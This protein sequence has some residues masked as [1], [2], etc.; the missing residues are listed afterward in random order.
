MKSYINYLLIKL[1]GGYN[2]ISRRQKRQ[3]LVALDAF[4]FCLAIYLAFWLRFDET[5]PLSGIV[6][7][8]W[9]IILLIVVKLIGFQVCGIYRPILRYT[10]LEFITTALQAV[11]YSSGVLVILA[12]L[13]GSWPLPRSVLII[14]AFLTLFLLIG[15]RLLIRSSTHNLAYYAHSNLPPERLV[16]YGAGAA[17]SQLAA[18]L[19]NQRTY[20]LIAF[21]DDNSDLQHRVVIQGLKVYSP[22]KLRLLWQ[23]KAFDTVILAMPSVTKETKRCI[24]EGL[25]SLSIP[26]KTVPS[27]NEILSGGVSIEKLRKIDIADLLGREEAAPDIELLEMQVTGKVVLV[28]GAGGSIGS[29]LCR[30]IAKQQPQ[31]LVLYELSEFALYNIDLELAETYPQLQ[32]FAYLGNVTDKDHLSTVLR[33]HQVET[34]YHAAAYKHVPLVEVNAARGIENNVLGTWTTVRCAIECAV[35]NFV[36]ISTDKAVRP[37]NIMG[38]SKRVAELVVQA[39]AAQPGHSTRFAIVRFGNVL[40]SSGSVVPRFSR[41]IAQGQPITVTDREITRYFMTIPE[42][43]RLV[44]QAGAMASGGEV[45]L[46]DMGEPIRIYDLALQMIRLSGLIPQQDI[47]IK[48]TGLRPGEKL[49][50]ELLISGDNVK[51]TRHHKIFS[52]QEYFWSWEILQPQLIVLL[53]KARL[54][55]RAGIVTQLCNLVPEYQPSGCNVP[56]NMMCA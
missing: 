12:Y 27:L 5:L 25:Q 45:F 41:Q 36:L 55:D 13:H 4:L 39:L 21:I 20:R 51:P 10:S 26:V 37:T 34:V 7:Y 23:Q 29:E 32:R 33:D 53:D 50:E 3:F 22:A 44:M 15:L 2:S 40:N 52:A 46:L 28:T 31:C 9:L 54:N 17:G 42:A 35:K 43:A 48:I 16:I 14:D 30:Q 24:L 18:A 1:Y 6:Q 11:F 38:A 47:E 19:A 49:Y 56:I 8:A